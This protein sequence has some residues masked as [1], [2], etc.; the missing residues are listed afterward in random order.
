MIALVSSLIFLLYFSIL[1][2]RNGE[3]VTWKLAVPLLVQFSIYALT[4]STNLVPAV[5]LVYGLV[6]QKLGLWFK[7]DT[8]VLVIAFMQHSLNPISLALS[9]CFCLP[10]YIVFYKYRFHEKNPRLVPAFFLAQ[11]ITAIIYLMSTI[12]TSI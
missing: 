11:S 6:F 10:I 12:P 5:A 9:I 2:Y 4:G 8:K 7:A 1:D 3:I